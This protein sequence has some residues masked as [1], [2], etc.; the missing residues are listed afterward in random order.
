MKMLP[1]FSG[2]DEHVPLKRQYPLTKLHGVTAQKPTK[3]NNHHLENFKTYLFIYLSRERFIVIKYWQLPRTKYSVY[4]KP[5]N[6]LNYLLHK[7]YKL[8]RHHIR[9]ILKRNSESVLK[10]RR[11]SQVSIRQETRGPP[12]K[13]RRVSQA[14]NRQET[15]GSPPKRRWTSAG[16]IQRYFLED[17]IFF[18]D[19]SLFCLLKYTAADRRWR[20]SL[21][22][23]CIRFSKGRVLLS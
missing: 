7:N 17:S 4:I 6:T 10:R 2:D 12:P 19:M 11:L 20:D 1:P 21:L 9:V 14:S 22:T 5:G 3:F 18:V 15:R 23:N 8:Y 13:R 16:T